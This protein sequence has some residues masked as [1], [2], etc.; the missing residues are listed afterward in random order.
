MSDKKG[1][2]ADTTASRKEALDRA[3][4]NQAAPEASRLPPHPA[5]EPPLRPS[6]DELLL[7]QRLIAEQK[8]EQKRERIENLLNGTLEKSNRQ[9]AETVKSSHTTVG[10]VR[11]E[12][13]STGQIDQLTKTVGKDGRARRQP[14]RKPGDKVTSA[15]GHAAREPG[16]P[17]S[18]KGEPESP[19]P[20]PA[21][22]AQRG[23]TQDDAGA[24]ETEGADEDASTP[25]TPPVP[26]DTPPAHPFEFQ[27]SVAERKARDAAKRKKVDDAA[28]SLIGLLEQHPDV[29]A[30]I[31]ARTARN[32]WERLHK[33]STSRRKD[34]DFGSR[35]AALGK[36]LEQVEQAFGTADQNGDNQPAPKVEQ[37]QRAA[38]SPSASPGGDV[39]GIPGFLQRAE[40]KPNRAPPDDDQTGGKTRK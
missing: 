32:I 4:D 30:V 11:T 24:S 23:R 20:T 33:R 10:T 34:T 15:Y 9:I 29:A 13:L 31:V 2:A 19:L 22:E 14:A 12:L 16:A 1:A 39:P 8:D 27:E 6:P 36:W 18:G 35:L 37:T 26:S 21:Q 25:T 7:R 5:V 17:L 28:L 40:P 38:A 3:Q